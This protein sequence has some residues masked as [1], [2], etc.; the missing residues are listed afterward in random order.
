MGHKPHGMD[1]NRAKAQY[2]VRVIVGHWTVQRP[3]SNPLV[4]QRSHDTECIRAPR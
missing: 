3:H 4:D 1:R 2:Q